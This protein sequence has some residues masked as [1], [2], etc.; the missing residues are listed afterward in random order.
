VADRI[1]VGGGL[2]HDPP[3][4]ENAGGQRWKDKNEVLAR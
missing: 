4:A 3:K 2:M 1:Y